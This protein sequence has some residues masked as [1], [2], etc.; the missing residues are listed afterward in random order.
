MPCVFLHPVSFCHM[1]VHMTMSHLHCCTVQRHDP[2]HGEYFLAAGA[3]FLAFPSATIPAGAA[4][5]LS[6][7]WA[8]VKQHLTV[9][10][11][12]VTS[13]EGTTKDIR[14]LGMLTALR[15]LR[16]GGSFSHYDESYVDMSGEVLDLKL[17]HLVFLRLAFVRHG[18]L[19]LSCPKLKKAWFDETKQLDIRIEDAILK[20]LLLDYCDEVDLAISSPRIQLRNLMVLRVWQC[21]EVGRRLIENLKHMARL[22]DMVYEDFPA[23]CMP[24][25]FQQS[26]EHIQLHPLDWRHD[27]PEGLKE[28][29]RPT[30]F[31]FRGKR[32]F[33]KMTRPLAE[34]LPVDRLKSLYLGDQKYV[35]QGDGDEWYPEQK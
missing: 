6:S 35:R 12:E 24:A 16:V 21:S 28:L 10:S 1:A 15:W 29:S 26:L 13:G 32:K 18:K 23:A 31:R 22:A 25:S 19:V 34:F 11:L 3:H 17:P 33:W 7:F 14:T 4:P 5:E 8:N 30:S 2:G 9:L 27:L 20:Y